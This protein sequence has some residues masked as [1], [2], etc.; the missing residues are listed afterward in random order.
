MGITLAESFWHTLVSVTAPGYLEQDSPGLSGTI[1]VRG[2]K[3]AISS[4]ALALFC[5]KWHFRTMARARGANNFDRL[6]FL[7]FI[8]W[9]WIRSVFSFL[10]PPSAFIHFTV[11][12][13]MA[14]A[15]T[16]SRLWTTPLPFK[17][18]KHYEICPFLFFRN[19]GRTLVLS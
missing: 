8:L 5:E 6:K 2:H 7:F 9:V 19:P 16:G 15:C 1:C 12:I 4:T 11:I 17:S 14:C 10:S 13:P 3:S 18:V